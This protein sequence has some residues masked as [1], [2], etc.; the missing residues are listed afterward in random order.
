MNSHLLQAAVWKRTFL[1]STNYV[2]IDD[3]MDGAAV[4]GSPTFEYIEFALTLRKK[5]ANRKSASDV[6]TMWTSGVRSGT[7][8]GRFMAS[9]WVL[10]NTER[11]LCVHSLAVEAPELATLTKDQRKALS[12]SALLRRR[13]HP[14][15]QRLDVANDNLK[16]ALYNRIPVMWVDNFN[17]QRYARNPNEAH[18]QCINGTVFAITGVDESIAGK[19]R[20]WPTLRG[21]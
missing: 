6:M 11:D 8:L 19:W 4:P 13:R 5:K 1:S 15:L 18:D 16:K 14:V 17:K 7:F 2:T 20:G 3:L 12:G 10:Y 21:I 9:L